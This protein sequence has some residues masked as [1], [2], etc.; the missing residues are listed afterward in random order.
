MFSP[1]PGGLIGDLVGRLPDEIPGRLLRHGEAGLFEQVRAIH[2]EGALAIERRGI[3][4]PVVGETGADR[5][6]EIVDVVI[7]AKLVE[8][9]QPALLRPDRGLIGADGEHVE[10]TALGGDVGCHLL[11]Q[12]VLFERDPVELDVRI[13]FCEIVRQL[14]HRDHIVVVHGADGERRI[15]VGGEPETRKRDGPQQGLHES[16]HERILR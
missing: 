6:K 10:L 16:L 9:K 13:G 2:D 12:H 11:A 5:R 7:G 15:S 1:Q 8:R 3:E 4:L 14:L